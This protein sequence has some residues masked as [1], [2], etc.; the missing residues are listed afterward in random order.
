AGNTSHATVE[1]QTAASIA[2]MKE[3]V[4]RFADTGWINNGGIENSLLKQLEHSSLDSFISH[5][6]AQ[7][8]KHITVDAANVLL[9]DANALMNQD[10]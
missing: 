4:T 1:F 5:V 7:K 8:N 9:R 10:Q 2:S 6:Q 3:L